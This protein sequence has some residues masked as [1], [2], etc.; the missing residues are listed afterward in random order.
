[1]RESFKMVGSVTFQMSK[2]DKK[3]LREKI[4]RSYFPYQIVLVEDEL[5]I[6]MEDGMNKRIAGDHDSTSRV[7]TKSETVVGGFDS[8]GE[9]TSM[10]KSQGVIGI[11]NSY[12][13]GV[14]LMSNTCFGKLRDILLFIEKNGEIKK[15][16]LMLIHQAVDTRHSI[17]TAKNGMLVEKTLD[18]GVVR[19]GLFSENVRYRRYDRKKNICSG[20]EAVGGGSVTHMDAI[21]VGS[22]CHSE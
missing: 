12:G 22:S 16:N 3:N 6:D 4:K 2:K 17:M 14:S 8:Y 7:L 11:N 10:K 21:S 5:R 9:T 19:R 20:D 13:E 1:M 15:A 18:G